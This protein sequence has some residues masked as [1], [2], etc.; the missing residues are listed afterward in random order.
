MVLTQQLPM[1]PSSC[2]GGFNTPKIIPP[3]SSIKPNS[4]TSHEESSTSP[5]LSTTSQSSVSEPPSGFSFYSSSSS[6]PLTSPATCSSIITKGHVVYQAYEIRSMAA[7]LCN[8]R[9]KG[10]FP[11]TSASTGDAQSVIADYE[12]LLQLQRLRGD[13][14]EPE[15]QAYTEFHVEVARQIKERDAIND[16]TAAKADAIRRVKMYLRSVQQEHR[17]FQTTNKNSAQ[18]GLGTISEEI[19]SII[20]NA[21]ERTIADAA[22]PLRLNI[23][24]LHNETVELSNQNTDLNRQMAVHCGIIKQQHESNNAL[25][26]NLNDQLTLVNGL[27]KSLSHIL[28]NLPTAVNR[29]LY[30]AQQTQDAHRGILEEQKKVLHDLE[31]QAKHLQR[32]FWNKGVYIHQSSGPSGEM[33]PTTYTAM[34]KRHGPR[35]RNPRG[36]MRRMI[37][38]VFRV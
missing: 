2:Y 9:Q 13:L 27:V 4:P 20:E 34:M 23:G 37:H 15:S 8:A 22:G 5:S 6:P 17:Y 21:A 24:N 36:G 19:Y 1:L 10:E 12:N 7:A 14:S 16:E 31:L 3:R 32:A 26:S 29:I 25:T 33:S 28:A 38:K 35:V 30:S 11:A 18:L